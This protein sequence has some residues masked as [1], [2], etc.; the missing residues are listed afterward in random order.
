LRSDRGGAR[1]YVFAA[2]AARHQQ[3]CDYVTRVGNEPKFAAVT[4]TDEP[5]SKIVRNLLA[6]D[7]IS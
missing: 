5:F 6:P 2:G 1:L 4:R 7:G 3:D